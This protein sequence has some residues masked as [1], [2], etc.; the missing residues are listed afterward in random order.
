MVRT[1]AIKEERT[2]TGSAT[3]TASTGA[4][5][6][7]L[8]ECTQARAIPFQKKMSANGPLPLLELSIQIGIKFCKI[9]GNESLMI[10]AMFPAES[11]QC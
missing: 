5:Q 1:G 10:R 11:Y 4:A 2:T 8:G 3:L 9:M 7:Y 6:S